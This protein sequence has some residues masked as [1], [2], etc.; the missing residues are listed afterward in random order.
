MVEH[1]TKEDVKP[2]APVV[3]PEFEQDEI[4]ASVARLLEIETDT[5]VQP[6]L[7]VDTPTVEHVA[8]RQLPLL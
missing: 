5:I 6:G 2:A 1:L 8:K 7:F 3:E 4:A